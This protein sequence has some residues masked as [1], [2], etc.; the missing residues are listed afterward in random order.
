MARAHPYIPN[1]VPAIKDEMLSAV[2]VGS[3]DELYEVIP[4]SL[5]LGRL[6]DLPEPYPSE[7]DLRRHVAE[8]LNRN[9]STDEVLSFLGGGVWP[10]YVP[11]VC[12]E[13]A[14]RGEFVT[15]YH[16]GSR[17]MLGS[18]QAQSRACSAS[19]WAWIS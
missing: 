6:L 10:H 12:D 8:L 2:G 13:V 7:Y 19:S 11:A 4:E 16:D 1:S 5:R 14:S 3:S 15:A 9:R 18:Y 17:S